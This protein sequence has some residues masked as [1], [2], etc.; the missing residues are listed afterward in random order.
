MPSFA[1]GFGLPVVEALALGAPVIASDLPALREAGGRAPDY[2][3][4]LDGPGWTAAVLD[5]AKPDSAMRRAQ[6]KR[7]ATWRPP[8]WDDHLNLALD[9]VSEVCR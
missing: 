6:L 7:M 3:D 4:P 2:L 9:F 1:E 5:Y 8:N